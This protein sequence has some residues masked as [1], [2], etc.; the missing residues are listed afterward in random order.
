[1]EL[2]QR[3]AIKAIVNGLR[4]SGAIGDEAMAGIADELQAAA[5]NAD[6]GGLGRGSDALRTLA[7]DIFP[8]AGGEPIILDADP[9]RYGWMSIPA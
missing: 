9:P 5:E 2:V 4:K 1:M 3:L 6:F 8:G 7:R